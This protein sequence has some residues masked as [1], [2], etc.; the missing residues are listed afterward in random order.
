MRKLL[1]LITLL[2]A[3]NSIYAQDYRSDYKYNFFSNLEV[4]VSGI[5]SYS[6]QSPHYKNFGA[7]IRLTKR[8]GDFWRIRGIAEINGFKNNGF[9][10]FGKITGGISF[11]VLP[12]YMFIDYGV[13]INPSNHSKVGLTADGG[14]GLQFKVGKGNIYVEGS[15]DRSNNGNLWQSNVETKLGYSHN[16]GITERDRQ[17]ISIKDNQPIIYEQ[18]SNENN[19]LKNNLN[20]YKATNEQLLSTL[21]RMNNVCISLEE[22]LKSCEETKQSSNR[23]FMPIF[24]EYASYSLNYTELDKI[25]LIAEEMNKTSSLVK[26]EITG[27]CSNNGADYSNQVLSENRAYTVFSALVERGVSSARLSYKGAGKTTMY[28][29]GESEL[30][31]VVLIKKIN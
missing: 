9:D 19:L 30:N 1:I 27:Y 31:Q 16:L 20:E 29:N 8:I 10:R 11:D 7:D 12:F 14:I 18:L 17:N 13:N 23:E 26:Y 2:I 5:Y 24:F 6:L 15:V 22:K 25:E 21:E 28:M 4:G 3:V